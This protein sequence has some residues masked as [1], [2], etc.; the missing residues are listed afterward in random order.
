MT[1]CYQNSKR[2]NLHYSDKDVYHQIQQ[3]DLL[4]GQQQDYKKKQQ[5]KTSRIM[6]IRVAWD[7]GGRDISG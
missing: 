6:N 2:I 3:Q 5:K 1:Y 7:E 4:A